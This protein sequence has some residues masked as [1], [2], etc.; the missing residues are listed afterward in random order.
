MIALIIRSTLKM[1]K[2][3]LHAVLAVFGIM[4]SMTCHAETHFYKWVDAKGTTHY[5]LTPP[6]KSAR[7][8]KKVATYND[9]PS[10]TV[11][12]AATAV[13]NTNTAQPPQSSQSSQSSQTPQNQQMPAHYPQ[14]QVGSYSNSTHASNSLSNDTTNTT[15][16]NTPNSV[17][18]SGLA[19]KD[20]RS[21]NPLQPLAP[22]NNTIQLPPQQPDPTRGQPMPQMNR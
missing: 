10:S 11:N 22:S 19:I 3:P 7:K 18:M 1:K 17:A 20:N 5:T 15:T 14:Q 12:A 16:N 9:V 2:K 8:I 6:P 13:Q 4:A 21:N